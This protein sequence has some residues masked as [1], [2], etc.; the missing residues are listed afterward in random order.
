MNR[1]AA[2]SCAVAA[3]SST[4][5]FSG[6][7]LVIE[8]VLLGSGLRAFGVFGCFWIVYRFWSPTALCA[9]GSLFLAPRRRARL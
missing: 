1:L 9:A 2:T 7:A 3:T 4:Q 5:R 8:C 6:R